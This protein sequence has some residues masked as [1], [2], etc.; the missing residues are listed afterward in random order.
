MIRAQPDGGVGKA[1]G[2]EPPCSTRRPAHKDHKVGQRLWRAVRPS[3]LLLYVLKTI[4]GRYLL[5]YRTLFKKYDSGYRT[6]ATI[7]SFEEGFT[8][9]T[10]LPSSQ[11]W[12]TLWQTHSRQQP[13]RLLSCYSVC[14]AHRNFRVFFGAFET[15]QMS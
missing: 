11:G 15:S 1:M 10:I 8:V 9:D 3:D 7:R 14:N 13:V 12:Q 5:T 4:S 2:G 6:L